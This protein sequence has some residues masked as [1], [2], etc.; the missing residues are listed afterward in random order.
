[1][2]YK[3]IF[4]SASKTNSL[5]CLVIFFSFVFADIY[6]QN[7]LTVEKAIMGRYTEFARKS[8]S[9]GSFI[10][11][12]VNFVYIKNA[13]SIMQIE[14]KSAN[15][16]LYLHKSDI[17]KL[18]RDT[19]NLFEFTG[20]LQWIDKERLKLEFGNHYLVYNVV[21]KQIVSSILL[22]DSAEHIERSHDGEKF[23]YTIKNNL[24]VLV[25][26]K[27]Q[28]VT[29]ESDKG[30]V[31]GQTVSRNEFGITK[32]TFWSPNNNYLAFYKKDETEVTQ[33][34]LL[35]ISDIPAQVENIRYPMA[36]GKSEHIALGVYSIASKRIV[37]IESGDTLN[38]YLTCV[39][40]SPDEKYIFVAVLNRAQN[41][42]KL[43][44]YDAQTGKL[45]KTL[46]EESH[47]KYVEPE[48]ALY[49]LPNKHEF[50]WY[51]ARSGFKHW[52]RY[53]IEG[54]LLGAAT[55]G[56][57]ETY[58]IEG[59]DVKKN[60]IYCNSTILSPLDVTPTAFNI[61]TAKGN[62]LLNDVG[63]HSFRLSDDSKVIFDVYESP[64]IAREARFV[65]IHGKILSKVYNAGD[66]LKGYELGNTHM[67]TLTST[68]GKT[69]LY[70]RMV[71]PAN[72]EKGRKYPV[73]VYVYGGPH[74]Q[75]VTHS[76]LNEAPLWDH[77]MA[78]KGYIV[79]TLDNR[80]S[81]HRGLAFEN[82]I[83]RQLGVCE[84]ADQMTGIQ[85]LKSLSYVDS[86][87]I[88]VFGWSF[89]GFMTLSLM[90]DHAET[91]KVGVAG[92]PVTD[93]NLYEVMYGE[94]Y[95]DTP[96][97][98]PE[99]Y[100]KVSVLDKVDKLKGNVLVIHGG[101]D[102]TVVPQQSF[103]FLER[104]IKKNKQVDFFI[105]PTHEHNVRG[106]DRVHLYEKVT[107]Y[108]EEKL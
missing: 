34:P 14:P 45:D 80:G 74:N 78:S 42:L 81:E 20:S 6:A 9:S 64:S 26:S 4:V 61:A 24:Y 7:K 107:Q 65:D 59:V 67:L 93:W 5:L 105:Y 104:C 82:A 18:L 95:M 19:T 47:P 23:A 44:R 68:D 89:G 94:R 79:F 108:F 29:Y 103:R 50:L 33:Y 52:Y 60:T 37:Y 75:L 8:F 96:Q 10:P 57:F 22:P 38:Q 36:G 35:T 54:E 73:I 53:T 69:P 58:D 77:S 88:G 46:F 12:S 101:I 83:H 97:E 71:T 28:V 17:N 15:E 3:R 66:L 70:A 99:G 43:N 41:H 106:K 102:P 27:E 25:N 48:K 1:M 76:W 72:V 40:W 56:D 63:I 2:M 51:S 86:T 11:Q 49:F 16:K 92:G 100:A 39:S 32:G 84:M 55:S 31:N 30:V 85:Y 21:K 90:T 91:F 13:D 62:A 87:R 98:N